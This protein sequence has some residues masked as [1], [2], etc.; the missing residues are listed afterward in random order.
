MVA[1]GGSSNATDADATKGQAA[2]PECG[3]AAGTSSGRPTPTG[4]D[5]TSDAT[6]SDAATAL[7]PVDAAAAAAAKNPGA[8]SPAA[9]LDQAASTTAAT[10]ASGSGMANGL[11]GAPSGVS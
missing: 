6:G 11:T 8:P 4:P 10:E 5:A 7:N 9:A 2:V 1:A 3:T